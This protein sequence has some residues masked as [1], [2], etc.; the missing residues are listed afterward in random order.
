MCQSRGKY[1][2]VPV[3]LLEFYANFRPVCVWVIEQ[4]VRMA[5]KY[6]CYMNLTKV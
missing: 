2:S 3:Y 6:V 4:I 5:G 1:L